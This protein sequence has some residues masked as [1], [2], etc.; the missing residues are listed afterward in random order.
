MPGEALTETAWEM[1]NAT[2]SLGYDLTFLAGYTNNYMGYFAPPDEYDAGDYE[3]LLTL[4]GI[5]TAARVR[6]NA[7]TLARKLA[8]EQ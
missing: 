5:D 8:P 2:Q 6:D 4:W 1:R 7:L 3:S